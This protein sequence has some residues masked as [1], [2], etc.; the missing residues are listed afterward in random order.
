MKLIVAVAK[1]WGIGCD[2]GLLF[3]LPDDMKFFKET[4]INNVVVMGRPTLLSFPGERPLKD[5]TN[6]VLTKDETFQREG[7]IVC[8]SM[9]GLFEELKKYDTND[10]FIIEGLSCF[11]K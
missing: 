9:E 6:I 5:R 1:D 7:I 8:H 3:N 2:G 4:T 10:I 11:S